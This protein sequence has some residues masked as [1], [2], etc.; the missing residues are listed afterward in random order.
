M[1]LYF[2]GGNALLLI[3]EPLV[4]SEN[5]IKKNFK[6]LSLS[7]IL[8]ISYA[9]LLFFYIFKNILMGCFEKIVQMLYIKSDKNN[10]KILLKVSVN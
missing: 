7:I 1:K 5:L 2:F 3:L 4:A 8:F 9:I 6:D 10:K